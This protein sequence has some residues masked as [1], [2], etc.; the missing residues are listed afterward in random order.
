MHCKIR[1]ICETKRLSAVTEEM[2]MSAGKMLNSKWTPCRYYIIAKWFLRFIRF[3]SIRKLKRKK[4]NATRAN[5]I[6]VKKKIVYISSL[7]KIEKKN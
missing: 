6:K 2:Q 5:F 4:K 7:E 1:E 3:F